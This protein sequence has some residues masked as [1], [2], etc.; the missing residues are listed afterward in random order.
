MLN[1]AF[2]IFRVVK[3]KARGEGDYA[4]QEIITRETLPG[5]H[6]I[7]KIYGSKERRYQCVLSIRV[8]NV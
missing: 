2:D 1:R 6:F 5:H 7:Y 3:I 4:I 8:V